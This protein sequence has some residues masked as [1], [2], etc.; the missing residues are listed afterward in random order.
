RTNDLGRLRD[1][2]LEYAGVTGRENLA[3]LANRGN[4]GFKNHTLGRLLCPVNKVAEF[5]AD[6]ARCVLKRKE[7][8]KFNAKR[9]PL[10]LYDES[11]LAPGKTRRALFRSCIMTDAYKLCYRG[12]LAVNE[13]L[14][15][16]DG[17]STQGQPSISEH[18]KITEVSAERIIYVHVLL[19]SML[20]WKTKDN[21]WKGPE[22]VNTLCHIF[23]RPKNAQWMTDLLAWWNRYV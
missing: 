17:S 14:A 15:D 19:S 12:P 1:H 22:F 10:F 9:L 3:H 6:P 20:R 5:D 7:G 11:L 4:R 2:I 23:C 13:V 8:Y 18:Y 16:S 21:A